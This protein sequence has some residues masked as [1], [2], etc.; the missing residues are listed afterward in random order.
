MAQHFKNY[1][2]ELFLYLCYPGPGM[3]RKNGI[4]W[5]SK[6]VKGKR[7]Q[8]S[9]KTRNKKIAEERYQRYLKDGNRQ[10]FTIIQSGIFWYEYLH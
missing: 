6:T 7:I 10:V 1:H 9:L 8:V 2:L 5:F 3:Y 4:Y